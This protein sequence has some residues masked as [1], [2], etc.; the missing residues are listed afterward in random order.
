MDQE[1]IAYLDGRFREMSQEIQGLR[2]ETSEQMSSLRE[3]LGG[4]IR[5]ARVLV[6][7]MRSEIQLLAEGYM[8]LGDQL[9]V[10]QSETLLKFDEVKGSMIPY[11]Q[12]L[13]R[14]ITGLEA[15]ASRQDRDIL[16]VFREK[17]GKS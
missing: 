8:G 9:K 17:Y 11:Y 1:L 3:E 4:E 6:E 16:E 2:Q 7:A 5:Q 14:R 15:K 13:N 10:H 12:D